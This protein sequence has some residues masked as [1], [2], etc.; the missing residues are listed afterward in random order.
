MTDED[1]APRY[2]AEAVTCLACEQRDAA[3]QSA[4]DDAGGHRQHGVFW[5]V[6]AQRV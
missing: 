3:A 1:T 2:L 5:S 4:V 6:Q